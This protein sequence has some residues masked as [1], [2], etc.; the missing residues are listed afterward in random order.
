M[1][2]AVFGARGPE[3]NKGRGEIEDTMVDVHTGLRK[4]NEKE[5]TTREKIYEGSPDVP[6][7]RAPAINKPII[8]CKNEM[9]ISYLPTEACRWRQVMRQDHKHRR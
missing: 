4:D 7:A 5:D 1:I 8:N 6:V 2:T 9:F 3:N